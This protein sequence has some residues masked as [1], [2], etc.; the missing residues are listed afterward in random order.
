MNRIRCKTSM[1]NLWIIWKKSSRRSWKRRCRRRKRILSLRSCLKFWTRIWPGWKVVQTLWHSTRRL[2]CQPGTNSAREYLRQSFPYH[3]ISSPKEKEPTAKSWL[4][5]K[6]EI[7]S[8][9]LRRSRM[10]VKW[11]RRLFSRLG[12]PNSS[13][14]YST[15]QSQ[16]TQKSKRKYSKNSMMILSIKL[17]PIKRFLRTSLVTLCCHNGIRMKIRRM[18]RTSCWW[19]RMTMK[20]SSAKRQKPRENVKRSRVNTSRCLKRLKTLRSREDPWD[21]WPPFLGYIWSLWSSPRTLV[22]PDLKR[23]PSV[24]SSTETSWE[25]T[26]KSPELGSES[27]SRSHFWQ[28][29]LIPNRFSAWIRTPWVYLTHRLNFK[30]GSCSYVW[31]SKVFWKIWRIT[32]MSTWCRYPW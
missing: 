9:P 19:T 2:V 11:E 14:N 20:S 29:S 23:G 15:M 22:K 28:F 4:Q 31:E 24:W 18:L 17:K 1:H 27:L 25:F 6:G 3:H 10:A 12:M 7:D 30:K 26:H 16:T 5:H 21:S 32:L 13:T 8:Q